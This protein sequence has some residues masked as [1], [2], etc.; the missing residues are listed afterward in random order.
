MADTFL[1]AAIEE[2]QLGVRR[3]RPACGC[4]PRRVLAAAHLVAGHPNR[5]GFSLT[6]VRG[7]AGKNG[8]L[9]P[10]LE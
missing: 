6:L 5:D 9:A 2:A 1:Q 3:A 8:S 7:E 10:T 4:G